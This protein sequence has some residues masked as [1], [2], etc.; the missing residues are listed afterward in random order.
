MKSLF[1]LAG[2]LLGIAAIVAV[3][4]GGYLA[5]VYLWQVYSELDAVVRIVLLSTMAAVLIG[6]LLIAGAIKASGLAANR[7]Q[8]MEAKLRLYKSLVEICEPYFA[9]IDQSQKQTYAEML[10]KLSEIEAEM[11]ILSAGPVLESYG[12]LETAFRNRDEGEQARKLFQKLI[13]DIRRDLG[14][15]PNYNE[16]KRKFLVTS[17]RE[18]NVETP[19]HGISA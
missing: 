14:H 17:S 8:L 19:G 12:K 9:S 11:Q 10:D 3:F 1:T 7:G 16:S 4:Y 18:K 13:I 2:V 15:A 5:I 6:A